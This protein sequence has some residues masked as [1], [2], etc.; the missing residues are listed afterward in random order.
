M[1]ESDEA[2]CVVCARVCCAGMVIRVASNRHMIR[3]GE[4]FRG[5]ICLTS[6]VDKL[7]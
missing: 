4:N 3:R 6:R 5:L 7:G 1:T 2:G